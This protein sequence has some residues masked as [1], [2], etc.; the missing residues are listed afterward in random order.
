M[1][2]VCLDTVLN[3]L[4]TSEPL[5]ESSGWWLVLPSFS[6]NR[7][8][9]SFYFF[10]D[11]DQI[12]ITQ[13]DEEEGPAD[14]R[15]MLVHPSMFPVPHFRGRAVNSPS[16]NKNIRKVSALV[17][18]YTEAR[19]HTTNNFSTTEIHCGQ[20]RE[21]NNKTNN[22]GWAEKMAKNRHP[23]FYGPEL[24]AE[25]ARA[26]VLPKWPHLCADDHYHFGSSF[27]VNCI[28]FLFVLIPDSLSAIVKVKWSNRCIV[29]FVF[30]WRYVRVA[31][32]WRLLSRG[33]AQLSNLYPLSTT[34]RG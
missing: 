3:D 16:A 5:N 33:S 20:K 28:R 2:F 12:D 31:T 8:M 4:S 11:T 7:I 34:R 27:C 32:K 21:K 26:L 19:V 14:V 24:E 6:C 29:P 9:C 10:T 23:L 25:G 15:W 1:N 22:F 18:S 30:W 17:S 13:S